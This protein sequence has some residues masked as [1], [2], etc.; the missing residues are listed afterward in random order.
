MRR[1]R[2]SLKSLLVAVTLLALWLG[3]NAVIVKERKS[4]LDFIRDKNFSATT[5]QEGDGS[6]SQVT[7]HRI[8][9]Y[10]LEGMRIRNRGG[11]A[12]G[13]QSAGDISWIRR[14]LGDEAVF[15]ILVDSL[16]ENDTE[17]LGQLR[18][19]FP[20]ATVVVTD[21]LEQLHQESQELV[22]GVTP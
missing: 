7:K 6:A 9:P 20:E 2:F 3:W 15:F 16:F 1:P 14:L 11:P 21:S 17:Q 18:E 10:V 22:E 4:W 5:F 19:A 8:A 13:P 12:Y